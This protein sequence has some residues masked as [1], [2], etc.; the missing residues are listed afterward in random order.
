MNENKMPSNVNILFLCEPGELE[1]GT[2]RATDPNWSLKV[3]T[4]FMASS[5]T[6]PDEFVICYL[7]Y[8][9]RKRGFVH[10]E[11][12]VVSPNT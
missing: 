6:K 9:P 12:I 7:R 3:Y 1:G 4:L 2:K 11:L 5:V 8:G 10:E